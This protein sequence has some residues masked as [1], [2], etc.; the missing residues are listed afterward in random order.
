MASQRCE[1]CGAATTARTKVLAAALCRLCRDIWACTRVRP[2]KN[3]PCQVHAS[4]SSGG[5]L[6]AVENLIEEY[7]TA[8]AGLRRRY[9]WD[10]FTDLAAWFEKAEMPELLYGFLM[11]VHANVLHFDELWMLMMKLHECVS[12]DH[13][14]E[15]EVLHRALATLRDEDARTGEYVSCIDLLADFETV[16]RLHGMPRRRVEELRQRNWP[17][18][19]EVIDALGLPTGGGNWHSEI[20]SGIPGLGKKKGRR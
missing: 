7:R 13:V 4:I 3:L 20:L 10:V 1:C 16:L 9:A 12:R 19:A 6:A 8:G 11:A 5:S 14:P 2:S 18:C 15:L 17:H